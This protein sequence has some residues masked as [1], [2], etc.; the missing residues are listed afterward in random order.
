MLLAAAWVGAAP[1]AAASPGG[2]RR[3][4][5]VVAAENVWGSIAAQIGGR[6]VRVVSLVTNPRADPHAY[7]PTAADARAVARASVV[8]EN[9]IGYDP[10]MAQLLAAD[11]GGPVVLDVGR[12][13]G[14]AAGG[15]PHRWY[16]PADVRRVVARVSADLARADP[17][18]AAYFSR[19]RTWF[20]TV[21]LRG[22]DSVIAAIKARYAGTPVGASESIFALMAP[23]LGLRLVTPATFLRA[24]SEGTDVSSSD[25]Q[26][27][28]RQI[29]THRIAVYVFNRQ[30]VTPVVRVQ[31]D[32]VRGAKIPVAG[33]TETLEPAGATFQAWQTKQLR[34]VEAALAA[35]RGRV[36]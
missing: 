7:E 1:P 5:S 15:N 35:A 24:V 22:Y 11:G 3:V 29:R 2:G 30:N 19:R 8:I 23:A 32:E 36:R 4:V 27:I 6:H 10:W 28:D 17:A 20:L 18:D 9:G 14:V 13:L 33:I 12:L 16:D 34:S 26:V 31:L 25:T 21:A